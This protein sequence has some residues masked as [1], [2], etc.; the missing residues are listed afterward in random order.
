MNEYNKL[1]NNLCEQCNIEKI[2]E[3]EEAILVCPNCGLCEG[4]PIYVSSYTHIMK[5]R[6]RCIYKRDEIV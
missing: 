4:Y 2:I 3:Y 1:N 6:K 5:N